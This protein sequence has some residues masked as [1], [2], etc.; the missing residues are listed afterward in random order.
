VNILTLKEVGGLIGNQVA[1]KILR[2]VH[3][4]GD[5]CSPEVGA[6]KK[7]EKGGLTARLRFDLDGS[8]YHGKC[9]LGL[10]GGGTRT[11]E[12]LH[13]AKSL[14]GA[15]AANKPPWRFGSEKEE[16]QERSLGELAGRREEGGDSSLTG[17]IHCK[18]R[19]IRQA[20]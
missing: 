9:C 14:L 7:V 17:K 6:F 10:L 13:G 16:N 1:G 15:S 8:F 11:S 19:G 4:A 20:Q 3:H 18:A 2:R 5:D 12:A